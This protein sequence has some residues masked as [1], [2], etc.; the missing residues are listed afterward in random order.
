VMLCDIEEG[1]LGLQVWDPRR[2]FKDRGHL[3]PIITPAYPC[4]NS[5]YNVSASTLRVMTEEFQRGS[6][7]CEVRRLCYALFGY[8]LI[9]WCMYI[10]LAME[11]GHIFSCT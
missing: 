2:N 4:M 5:S 6:D 1:T 8:L 3:M 7:I 11:D 9:M 10:V